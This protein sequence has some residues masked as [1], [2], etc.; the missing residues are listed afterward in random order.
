MDG[1]CPRRYGRLV[2]IKRWRVRF[3]GGGR[4]WPSEPRP[5]LAQLG[6]VDGFVSGIDLATWIEHEIALDDPLRHLLVNPRAVESSAVDPSAA[7]P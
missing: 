2:L 4:Q 7:R 5:L 1:H 3:T 6:C